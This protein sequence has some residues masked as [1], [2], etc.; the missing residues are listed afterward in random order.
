MELRV[1]I[2]WCEKQ[3]TRGEVKVTSRWMSIVY[4][5]FLSLH[6]HGNY[7]ENKVKST[8]ILETREIYFCQLNTFCWGISITIIPVFHN[9][10]QSVQILQNHERTKKIQQQNVTL[11]GKWTQALTF[12]WLSVLC[13]TIWTNS[14]IYWKPHPFGSLYSHTLLIPKKSKSRKQ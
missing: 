9:W 8:G 13:A 14:P 4:D 10:L 5:C 1:S 12:L 7:Q 11:T 2:C 6:Q 3:I